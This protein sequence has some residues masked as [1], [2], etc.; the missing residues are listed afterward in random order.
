M[1]LKSQFDNLKQFR[2]GYWNLRKC[3]KFRH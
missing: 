3:R 1:P 2:T